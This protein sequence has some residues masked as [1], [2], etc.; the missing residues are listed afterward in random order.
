M[1][2]EYIAPDVSK[3]DFCRRLTAVLCEKPSSIT[4]DPVPQQQQQGALGNGS[5]PVSVA[6]ASSPV[7]TPSA[8]AVSSH[9]SQHAAEGTQTR[10]ESRDNGSVK[11]GKQRVENA[12]VSKEDAAISKSHSIPQKQKQ[13]KEAPKGNSARVKQ[14]DN[15]QDPK[16]VKT[17]PASLVVDRPASHATSETPE[18]QAKPTLATPTP[19]KQYR[20]QVRLFD[21]S[22]VR[23]SF[24]PTQTIRGDVRPW[25][26][27]Q[28]PEK[29]RPYNLK[30]ILAP[31]PNRT[32]S[33]TEEEQT[34]QDLNLGPT[35]NL[36]MIPINSYTEAY[37]ASSSSL[38]V[39]GAYA[40]YDLVS[41]AVG[42]VTKLVGSFLG[43]GQTTSTAQSED[44]YV[45]A[46]GSGSSSQP[47]DR[48]RRAVRPAASRGSNVRTLRDH[49]GERDD[50]QFYNGN[51][52]CFSSLVFHLL[53]TSKYIY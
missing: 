49:R 43:Y 51:Q 34:L 48:V 40:V 1:L 5:A 42:N 35:A 25:L 9:Q 7:P 53:R 16:G 29:S 8:P 50:S 46:S 28:L 37:A 13:Q 30:H 19:P 21:G 26:N 27:E 24:S 45:T 14:D 12:K 41:S 36:V 38:P 20:L 11:A 15:R 18:V 23:S 47:D 3:D 10:T 2:Q 4:V 22:S 52:V 32:L 33:V 44:A 39:R 17:S 6:S 31:L